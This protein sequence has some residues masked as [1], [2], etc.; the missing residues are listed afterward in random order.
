MADQTDQAPEIFG[1]SFAEKVATSVGFFLI[2]SPFVWAAVTRRMPA[3]PSIVIAAMVVLAAWMLFAWLTTATTLEEDEIVVSGPAERRIKRSRVVHAE[4]L[5]R[6][7]LVSVEGDMDLE[8]P[9]RPKP[10][11]KK[12]DT[13]AADAVDA[14]HDWAGIDNSAPSA[15]TAEPRPQTIIYTWGTTRAKKVGAALLATYL[16]L[17][18]LPTKIAEAPD[19]ARWVLLNIVLVFVGSLALYRAA[20]STVTLQ[21]NEVIVKGVLRTRRASRSRVHGASVG[22]GLAIWVRGER[23]IQTVAISKGTF[24]K[25]SNRRTTADDIVDVIKDWAE[26]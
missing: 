5:H 17:G 7:V 18:F 12:N 9:F 25:L 4:A 15:P 10:R 20:T 21:E 24:S 2:L 1:I 16:V 14:I 8:I 26:G 13:R 22:P 3:V 6:S 11:W 19:V 23:A